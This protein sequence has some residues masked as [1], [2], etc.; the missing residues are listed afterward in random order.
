MYFKVT[1]FTAGAALVMESNFLFRP[2]V[3]LQFSE[4]AT[5]T[6]AAVALMA[7]ESTPQVL[8]QRRRRQRHIG[9]H[10]CSATAGNHYNGMAAVDKVFSC[11]QRSGSGGRSGTSS[12]LII[13]L[14][15]QRNSLMFQVRFW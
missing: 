12:K 6:A 5:A 9:R 10:N 13:K 3:E 8:A 14:Y 7:N 15:F 1:E 11:S 2:R 4:T